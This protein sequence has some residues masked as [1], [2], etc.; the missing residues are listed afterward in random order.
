MSQRNDARRASGRAM[1]TPVTLGSIALL[2]MLAIVSGRSTSGVLAQTT[3]VAS[4]V[5]SPTTGECAPAE[6]PDAA[7][8]ASPAASPVADDV[9]GLPEATPAGG[10]EDA[11]IDAVEN[12]IF[13]YNAGDFDALLTLVTP[14]LLQDKFGTTDASVLTEAETLPYTLLA[15]GNAAT[16]EDGRSSVEVVYL[17]GEYQYVTATWFLTEVDGQLLLDEEVLEAA[18]PDGDT[19]LVSFT[20]ADD[21]T[22]VAFEQFTEVA[23]NEVLIVYGANNATEQHVFNLY[24]LPEDV[25]ATPV[26]TADEISG[27]ASLVGQVSLAAG[28]RNGIALIAPAE[29]T[30]ALVDVTTGDAVTLLVTPPV[31]VEI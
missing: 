13:C 6:N 9:A 4:P 11:L 26:A 7:A 20:V 28:E 10:D 3:P 21:E 23:A 15:T 8:E 30:Y 24:L 14:K 27:D 25:A 22:P 1:V 29:G 12:V 5:A 31:E 17:A 16:Y 19:A 18:Q 2:V